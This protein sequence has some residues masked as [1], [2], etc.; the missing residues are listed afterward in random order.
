MQIIDHWPMFVGANEQDSFFSRDLPGHSQHIK[1]LTGGIYYW[2]KKRKSKQKKMIQHSTS[3]KK[4]SGHDLW[5]ASQAQ[6]VHIRRWIVFQYGGLLY[7]MQNTM[8][9]CHNIRKASAYHHSVATSIH[10]FI[11]SWH[12]LICS[13]WFFFFWAKNSI[14]LATS[15]KLCRQNSRELEKEPLGALAGMH[16]L[17]K[18]NEQPREGERARKRERERERERER[19]W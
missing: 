8:K 2:K 6:V 11:W 12:Y 7:Q 14:L 17:M 5:V 4:T 19:D 18:R 13:S 15:K 1:L 16:C 10:L 9:L 3:A